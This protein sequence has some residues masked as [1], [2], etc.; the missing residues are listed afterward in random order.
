MSDDQKKKYNELHNADVIRYEKQLMELKQKGFYL[1]EGGIKSTELEC[2]RN[3][4]EKSQSKPDRNKKLS[5]FRY[6]YV[7]IKEREDMQ[8]SARG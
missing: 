4:K 8:L 5:R 3:K 2:P 1:M 6:T 7:T